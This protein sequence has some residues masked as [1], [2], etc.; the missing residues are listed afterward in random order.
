MSITHII[1]HHL[2]L[3][4]PADRR[5]DTLTDPRSVSIAAQAPRDKT[6][7][8][9]GR[10]DRYIDLGPVPATQR[11]DWVLSITHVVWYHMVL[12]QPA[13]RRAGTITILRDDATTVI[14][15]RKHRVQLQ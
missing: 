9:R 13:C 8:K 14:I 15:E 12:T 4:Q 10:G 2:V 1:W 5:A 7:R 6:T 3:T 11:V